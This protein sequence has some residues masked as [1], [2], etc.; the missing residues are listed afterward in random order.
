MTAASPRAGGIDASP[1]GVRSAEGP[2]EAHVVRAGARPSLH[3]YDVFRD[4][5]RSAGS[6]EVALLALSGELLDEASGRAA[7]IALAFCAAVSIA[8]APVHAAVLTRRCGAP[9]AN[10]IAVAASALAE[11]ARIELDEHV[12]LLAWLEHGSGLV[13]AAFRAASTS[14]RLAVEDLRTALGDVDRAD[15]VPEGSI[16]LAAAR[17]A[18][19]FRLG[20]RDRDRLEAALVVARLPVALGEAL[21]APRDLRGYPGNLPRFRYVEGEDAGDG[22]DQTS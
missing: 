19:L 5:A 1:F 11:E 16:S 21:A 10:G 22:D 7:E 14:D 17:L 6:G 20:L 15:V 12:P 8:E 9:V 18:V 3:G 13:P 2:I 4:L